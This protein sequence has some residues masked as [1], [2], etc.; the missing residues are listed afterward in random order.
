MEYALYLF[1]GVHDGYC[2]SVVLWK[3]VIYYHNSE[4]HPT[5]DMSCLLCH[6]AC[7]QHAL[8]PV[9][10]MYN[11]VL[12]QCIDRSVPVAQDVLCLWYGNNRWFKCDRIAVSLWRKV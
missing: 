8:A 12:V 5:P 9:V 11:T 2:R 4:S 3:K 6:I 10:L 1:N 7:C